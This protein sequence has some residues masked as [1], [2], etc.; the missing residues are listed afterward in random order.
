MNADIETILQAIFED[1][2]GY[3]TRSQFPQSY[4]WSGDSLYLVDHLV[5]LP[6]GVSFGSIKEVSEQISEKLQSIGL[7]H[8]RQG[9][10]SHSSN[11]TNME[12][13]RLN[14][15]V[16][17]WAAMQLS[18]TRRKYSRKTIEGE[19]LQREGRSEFIKGMKAK[20]FS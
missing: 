3:S 4:V 14:T 7:G 16:T 10:V 20:L 18:Y 2:N 17:T 12:L 15:P 1:A 13:L 8:Y 9:I 19:L 5:V 11:G 6:F